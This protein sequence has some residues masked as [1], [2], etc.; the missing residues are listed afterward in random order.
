MLCLPISASARASLPL[1]GAAAHNFSSKNLF[2]CANSIPGF[3]I[4]FEYRGIT[5]ESD[6]Q[7]TTAEDFRNIKGALI[8]L[9][10]SEVRGDNWE[11]TAEHQSDFSIGTLTP[12]WIIDGKTV[13][14]GSGKASEATSEIVR[15]MVRPNYGNSK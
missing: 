14:L 3:G 15:Q 9:D 12:E 7:T 4:E 6:I 13:A 1:S 5:F 11:L 2:S 10:D 8:I